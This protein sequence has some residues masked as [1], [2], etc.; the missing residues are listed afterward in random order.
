MTLWNMEE[1]ENGKEE[2]G[3]YRKLVGSFKCYLMD[4]WVHRGRK[5]KGLITRITGF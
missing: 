1:N 3:L 2:K 5:R 4:V